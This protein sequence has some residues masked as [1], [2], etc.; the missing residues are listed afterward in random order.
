MFSSRL[1][2]FKIGG[3]ISSYDTP[4]ENTE[5]PFSFSDASEKNTDCS[6]SFT[7]C[8]EFSFEH[9]FSFSRCSIFKIEHS[10]ENSGLSVL[11]NGR[12]VCF[13]ETCS[14][15]DVGQVHKLD[16][17]IRSTDYPVFFHDSCYQKGVSAVLES[18]VLIERF[19]NKV[20]WLL[21]PFKKLLD[22]Q[23][24]VF[25]N[26]P[27]ENRREIAPF[28]NRHRGGSAISVTILNMRAALPNFDKTH[29]AKNN[30][31]LRRLQGWHD[32]HATPTSTVWVPTNSDSILG[33]PCSNRSSR[34]SFML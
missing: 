22:G 14:S 24:N 3:P 19:I 28:M 33:S 26:L 1:P 6:F 27:Q 18:H 8:P 23:S 12:S 13:T 30:A 25:C 21:S 17:R 20:E 5:H 32:T 4:E 15:K 10:E 11:K 16:P 31:N 29:S 9:S 7:G 34:T 2:F